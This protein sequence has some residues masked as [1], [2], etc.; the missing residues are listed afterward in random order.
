[1]LTFS[2][3][4]LLLLDFCTPLNLVT[5][6]FYILHQKY[7]LW[8]STVPADHL[9]R[10]HLYFSS[11]NI[12]YLISLPRLVWFK[13]TINSIEQTHITLSPVRNCYFAHLKVTGTKTQNKSIS[14]DPV[15]CFFKV[16]VNRS[17][18]LV[19]KSFRGVAEGFPDTYWMARSSL[20]SQACWFSLDFFSLHP[21]TLFAIN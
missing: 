18:F 13:W 6:W 20:C 10:W 9:S 14:V 16:S 17:F 15:L 12:R 5:T 7:L 21:F 19:K 11:Y 3:L 1:M 4:H 2:R 8:N